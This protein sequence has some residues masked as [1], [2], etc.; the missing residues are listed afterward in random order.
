M[1]VK[2]RDAEAMLLYIGDSDSERDRIPSATATPMKPCSGEKGLVILQRRCGVVRARCC[3]CCFD[4]RNNP[5]SLLA[6]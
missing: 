6:Q 4:I 3:A 2:R 1:V 5:L